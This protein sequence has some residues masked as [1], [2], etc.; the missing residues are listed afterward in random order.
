[1]TLTLAYATASSNGLPFTLQGL[2]HS[3]NEESP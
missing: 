3:R 2:I 1:M